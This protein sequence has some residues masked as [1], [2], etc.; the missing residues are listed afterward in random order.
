MK[1]II[2]LKWTKKLT[3]DWQTDRRTDIARVYA[4]MALSIANIYPFM[5]TY[6]P[7]MYLLEV[8]SHLSNH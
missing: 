2:G 8:Q 5:E 1:L 7:M 4:Y 3:A 6:H